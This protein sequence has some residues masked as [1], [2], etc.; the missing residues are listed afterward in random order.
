MRALRLTLHIY[1]ALLPLALAQSALAGS[2]LAAPGRNTEIPTGMERVRPA[3]ARGGVLLYTWAPEK[4]MGGTHPPGD[5]A[6]PFLEP[7][8]VT[9]PELPALMRDGKVQSDEIRV[10]KPDLILDY[11]STGS[12][13]AERA[14]KLQD[15][16]DAPVLLFDGKL[17]LTPETY[18]QLGSV[19]GAEA[20]AGELAEAAQRLLDLPHSPPPSAAPLR[21]YYARS[22]DG[23]VTATSASTLGDV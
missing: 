14:R 20:R 5:W 3:G 1:S 21:V 10:L 4:M 22:A 15:E 18:R 12:R 19:L 6:K 17:E 11:G 16:T 7:A 23:L 9:R 8:I 2:I 13:Y